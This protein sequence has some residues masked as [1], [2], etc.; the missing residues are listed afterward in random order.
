MQTLSKLLRPALIPADGCVYVVGDWA[1][2]EARVLP[3]LSDSNGGDGVLEVFDAGEDIYMHTAK[4][5]NVDDRFIGKVATLALGYQGGVRAFQAMAKT[6]RLKM[7]DQEAEDVKQKWRR[8]NPWAVSFWAKCEAAAIR[9]MR[10]PGSVHKVGKLTYRCI[11]GLMNV[12]LVCELPSGGWIQY[13]FARIESQTTRYG[14]QAVVTYAKAALTPA[15]D[16]TEWPRAGLY[17]GLLVENACQAV[18]A[19]LLRYAL[20]ELDGMSQN[21]VSHTHDEIMIE[22]RR[23]HAKST[24]AT[25]ATVMNT[26]P[27]W[28]SDLPLKA[29]PVIMERF[30]K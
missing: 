29:V 22:V 6:Y 24:V 16:A 17:G 25:L 10:K 30:G 8:A 12:T 7:A 26:P 2:I 20:W 9:A 18:A 13:P 21:V 19:D 23:E 5:M 14:T 1:A 27:A 15:A 11:P 3:W 4:A 28:A